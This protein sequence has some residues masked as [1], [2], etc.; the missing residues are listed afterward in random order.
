MRCRYAAATNPSAGQLDPPAMAAAHP[1]RLP[2]EI[3]ERRAHRLLVRRHQRP[4]RLLVADRE[5]HADALGRREGQIQR[6][7]PIPPRRRPQHLPAAGIAAADQR[8]KR[9]CLDLALQ[10]ERGRTSTQPAPLR[11]PPTRVV[12]IGGP[13]PPYGA[14]SRAGTSPSARTRARAPQVP[15]PDTL[16][17]VLLLARREPQHY[18]R[19]AARFVGRLALERPVDLGDLEAA[20]VALL[21]HPTP[22]PPSCKSSA[23][24][25]ACPGD[26]HGGCRRVRAPGASGEG[27]SVRLGRQ[28]GRGRGH[29]HR[30]VDGA[31]SSAAWSSRHRSRACV[32]DRAARACSR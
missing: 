31:C 15:L 26:R 3:P 29:V 19:A 2:L 7:H 32:T 30:D 16:A 1:T 12:V 4:R 17:I 11:L 10:A 22:A 23:N 27:R 14:R 8:P 18:S 25:G 5:Q 9:L 13:A 20:T 24:S 6:A 28:R 21:A